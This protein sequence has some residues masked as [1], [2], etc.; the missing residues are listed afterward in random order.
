MMTPGSYHCAMKIVKQIVKFFWF[1]RHL[2]F[3]TV[4]EIAASPA[5]KLVNRTTD[6]W[7]LYSFGDPARGLTTRQ[8][9]PWGFFRTKSLFSTA[10]RYALPATL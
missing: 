3:S 7:F 1:F 5:V 8:K 6:E 2:S 4:L 10:H 9:P